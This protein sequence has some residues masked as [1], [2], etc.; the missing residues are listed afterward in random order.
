[1]KTPHFKIGFKG[2]VSILTIALL[3]ACGGQNQQSESE[4]SAAL[5]GSN[6]SETSNLQAEN[7]DPE[8]RSANA[9]LIGS[10]LSEATISLNI[11]QDKNTT[12]QL[13]PEEVKALPTLEVTATA[14][15]KLNPSAIAPTPASPALLTAANEAQLESDQIVIKYKNSATAVNEKIAQAQAQ[16][17]AN[18][19]AIAI[20]KT[21]FFMRRSY[22]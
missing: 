6:S 8:L 10:N 15:A 19:S 2:L 12:A 16:S 1:M 3:V 5:E 13:S 18:N 9:G 4:N 14:N 11:E 17:Q 22:V 21:I 20:L 7:L